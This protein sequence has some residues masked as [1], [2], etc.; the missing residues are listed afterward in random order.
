MNN[1]RDSKQIFTDKALHSFWHFKSW[2][3]IIN[4]DSIILLQCSFRFQSWSNWNVHLFFVFRLFLAW[5]SVCVEWNCF[6]SLFETNFPLVDSKLCIVIV[7]RQSIKVQWQKKIMN[8]HQWM[9]MNLAAFNNIFLL[10]FFSSLP[11]TVVAV[12]IYVWIE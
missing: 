1:A 8:A 11:S 9:Q 7:Q 2:C 3:F 4:I 6:F 10:W 5:K 12:E